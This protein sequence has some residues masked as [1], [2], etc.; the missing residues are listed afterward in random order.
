MKRIGE[1]HGLFSG[2]AL[3]LIAAFSML[4]DHAGLMFFP[5]N[6]LLRIIGRLAYPIFAFMIAQGCCYT[7]NKL[8][9]F[10]QIFTLAAACQIVYYLV[11]GTAY[12]SILCTFSL[13][14]LMIYA[15]QWMKNAGDWLR[16]PAFL[17]FFFS[18]ASVRLL[19][20]YLEIDYGFWGC[21]VPVFAALFMERGQNRKWQTLLA[22]GAGLLLLAMDLG[23]IQYYSLLA[24]P[25]LWLYDGTRGKRPMKYFFYIFYPAHLALLQAIAW[26]I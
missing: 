13:S 12:F 26:L 9:Y 23:G 19:N 25:V 5:G 7:R 11:D 21:M 17:L 10:L 3:K 18:V 1:S 8:R 14:I 24:L 15:L 6:R 20:R 16:I 2:N 4:L 22:A